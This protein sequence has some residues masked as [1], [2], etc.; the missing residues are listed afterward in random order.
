[1]T[2]ITLARPAVS[3]PQSPDESRYFAAPDAFRVLRAW[4]AW[5][6]RT[7]DS[8]TTGF[9]LLRGDEDGPLVLTS[10]NLSAA[11][12]DAIGLH[13]HRPLSSIQAPLPIEATFERARDSAPG[14]AVT[15]RSL[16]DWAIELLLRTSAAVCRSLVVVLCHCEGRFTVAAWTRPD[17]PDARADVRALFDALAPWIER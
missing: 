11:S 1:M 17:A 6:A 15:L 5:A 3:E 7:R 14:E 16:D 12:L 13:S 2:L 8:T 4:R 9:A 10:Q